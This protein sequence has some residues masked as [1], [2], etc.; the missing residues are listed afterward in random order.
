[1]K[2]SITTFF[3]IS[4]DHAEDICFRL[5]NWE[6]WHWLAK[7]IPLMPAWMWFCIR[8][9]SLWF[10]TSSNPTLTFGGFDGESK[11]E[12]YEQLPPGSFPKTVYI[13][14]S[15]SFAEVLKLFES[16]GFTWP[17][18][19]KPDVGRMGFMFRQIHNKE[20][21]HVYHNKMSVDY[22]LQEF[23]LYP[24]E[25]SVFYYR[26]PNEN[27]GTITGFVRKD[28]LEVKGDG[29]STL[30]QLIEKYP[31]VRFRRD[32]MFCKHADRLNDVLPD[33]EAY[34]LSHALNLSRGGK[35]VSLEHEKDH[36]LLSVFD[37]LSLYAKH[38]YY[39]RYDI[40]CA[41]IEELKQG[42]NFTILEY[43]GSG[44]EPH[45]V[46]GNGLTFFQ[47]IKILLHHWS[48]LFR[49]SRQNNL[50]GIPYWDFARGYRQFRKASEHISILKKLDHDPALIS[51]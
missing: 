24:I 30:R 46:Y 12:M 32:E 7:Y 28:Y 26:F 21:L 29:K 49:I 48:I 4:L 23:V 36:R 8:S 35:L 27:K 9:R 34:C 42:K 25:V 3:S 39:G 41:S 15:L 6:T 45:H 16:N 14:Q 33:N 2:R 13:S 38:F 37:S 10:F 18:A 22:L 50:N 47:A 51:H 20:E 1:V 44:A 17:I 5:R 19:V 40:K 43:N 31:R 11:K